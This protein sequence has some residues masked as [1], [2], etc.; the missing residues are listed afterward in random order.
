MEQFK[1]RGIDVL[2]MP[3]PIDEFVISNLPKYKEYDLKSITSSGIEFDDES[4]KEKKKEAE[5]KMSEN[6]DFIAFFLETVWADKLE[7]VTLT[8]KLK[9]A[10]AVFT[11][12]EGQPS[13][14]M[15]KIMKSMWQKMPIIKRNF[16]INSEH[17][18]MEKMLNLYNQDKTSPQLK[19][20]IKYTYDQA[21]LLEGGEIE[22]MS[23]FVKT[24][25]SLV[26]W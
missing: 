14:Q 11:S 23:E 7:K 9:N 15:E 25:N 3:D 4:S 13:H 22:N 21:V 20:L 18:V 1:E 6:K 8:H 24:V 2:L 5:K 12:Q 19:N 17:P 16:E 10:L 26:S